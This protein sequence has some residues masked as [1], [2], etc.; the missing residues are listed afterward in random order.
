MRIEA[1]TQ[2]Q[3]IY[4][5]STT[6]AGNAKKSKAASDQLELSTMGRDYR[7]AKQAVTAAPDVREEVIAPLKK[8]INA[9]T[10]QVSN[11]SFANKLLENMTLSNEE[12]R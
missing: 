6:K 3:Q 1:Y 2:V 7:I 10:Y 4:K 8:S 12:M 9:G 5:T 11:E